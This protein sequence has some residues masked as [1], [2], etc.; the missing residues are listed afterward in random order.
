M[1]LK[2][3]LQI[4]KKYQ[5]LFILTII[6][7]VFLPFVYFYSQPVSY[8][9]SLILNVTRSGIQE[10]NDY[11]YDDFY[12]LQADE[13]FA[14]TLVEWLKSARFYEDIIS[15]S[16]ASPISGISAEKRS[17]QIVA[18][19][20]KSQSLEKAKKISSSITKIIS[21]KTDE[22]N[23]AQKESSW[24]RIVGEDPVILKNIPN[25]KIIFLASLL[26]GIF[27]AFWVALIKHYLE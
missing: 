24:F 12:R 5:K 18:V 20:F 7:V 26:M 25:Y 8:K 1:E 2:E 22:L 27:L 10:T 4:I 9:S 11:R 14:E 19:N 15:D 13:K 16:G 21:Q 6:I 17:S 3:Y 23:S